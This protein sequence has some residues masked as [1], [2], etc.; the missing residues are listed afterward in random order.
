MAAELGLHEHAVGKWRLRFLK[1]RCDRLL[2]E[3]RHGRART[4]IDDQVAELIERTPDATHWS[5]R[6][7]AA[8]TGFSH[9][10]I[11]PMWTAFGLKPHRSQTSNLSGDSLFVDKVRDLV[12]LTLSHP[13]EPCPQHR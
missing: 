11:R 8:E 3:A 4:I 10:T 7:L 2:D 9:T 6:S 1:D 13:T 5:I 12:A